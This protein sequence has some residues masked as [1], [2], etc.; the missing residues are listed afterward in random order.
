V[1]KNRVNDF[2]SRWYIQLPLGFK[3]L[4]FSFS[5]DGLWVAILLWAELKGNHHNAWSIA[6]TPVYAFKVEWKLPH[7]VVI[8]TLYLAHNSWY[9]DLIS[10]RNHLAWTLQGSLINSVNYRWD[11]SG[12][13]TLHAVTLNT[14]QSVEKVAVW[15]MKLRK[16]SVLM[17][18]HDSKS[19]LRKGKGVPLHAMEAH[20]GRGCIAPT[21]T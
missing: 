3:G 18:W 2:L 20:G 6:S 14:F 7:H 10:K 1:G 12:D 13:V 19:Y 8:N 21:H 17:Q 9:P 11:S 5:A 16:D 4:L 15:Q